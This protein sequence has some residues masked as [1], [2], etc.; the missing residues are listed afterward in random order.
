MF[1]IKRE[2]NTSMPVYN[3]YQKN[4]ELNDLG[5]HQRRKP[6]RGGKKNSNTI[7]EQENSLVDDSAKA[8]L[9]KNLL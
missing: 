7:I 9:D 6:G 8:D 4:I 5:K 3:I 2:N 1:Q